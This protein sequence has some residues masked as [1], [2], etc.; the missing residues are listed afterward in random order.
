MT[1][2]QKPLLYDYFEKTSQMML[3]E[4]ERSKGQKASANRGRNRE[5]F[6]DQFLSIALPP[7]LQIRNGEIQDS[8]GHHTGQL[9]IIVVRE[10]TP[11]I[12]YS[13]KHDAANTYLIEGVFAVIEVKS[14]L[15]RKE[16]RKA[17]ETLKQV[18]LLQPSQE[19]VMHHGSTYLDRPLR[20]IFSYES[21]SWE[22]LLDELS[23]QDYS[24]TIDLLCILKRGALISN[25]LILKNENRNCVYNIASGNASALGMLYFHLA[26][27]A[28]SFLVRS[29]N[30]SPYFEPFNGW[31]EDGKWISV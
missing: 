4:Y 21:V 27:Y 22:T 13:S 10:D 28:L 24:D 1:L 18:A 2:P 11:V 25:A 31:A 14:K 19:I 17:A 9:E 3:S 7:R 15:D 23:Q 12:P 8:K 26:K 20:C 16:L 30:I 5:I 29:I 6:C